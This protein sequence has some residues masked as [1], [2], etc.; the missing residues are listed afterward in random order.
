MFS[1]DG[2]GNDEGRPLVAVEERVLRGD[3][4]ERHGRLFDRRRSEVDRHDDE[5]ERPR[6]TDIKDNPGFI[7]T[8]L[9]RKH[10]E[11]VDDLG[12]DLLDHL[13]RERDAHC[14]TVRAER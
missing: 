12:V 8:V 1:E 3:P 5:I 4:V 10:S 11:G 13:D 9:V 2:F 7:V 14:V 6:I